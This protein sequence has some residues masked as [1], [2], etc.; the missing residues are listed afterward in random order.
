MEDHPAGRILIVD[1]NKEHREALG[2]VLTQA[3]YHVVGLASD[4]KDAL[5]LLGRTPV[6]LIIADLRM[7]GMGGL[8]LL[9]RVKPRW[10]SIQVI[11]LTAFGDVISHA[12]AM[13]HGASQFLSKPVRRAEILAQTRIA[14]QEARAVESAIARDPGNG[15]GPEE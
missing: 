13:E 4:G 11:I 12:E 5:A 6:D 10:P 9:K 2:R 1:D 3:G 14:V 8:E 15:R 7:P